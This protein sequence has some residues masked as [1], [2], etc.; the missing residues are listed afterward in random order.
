MNYGGDHTKRPTFLSPTF[1]FS[2]FLPSF[3]VAI[4]F[5]LRLPSNRPSII[6]F[7]SFFF[8]LGPLHHSCEIYRR[9]PIISTL[10]FPQL[11]PSHTLSCLRFTV[12]ILILFYLSLSLALSVS[13]CVCL[14]VSLIPFTDLPSF[15]EVRLLI[16]HLFL[17]V[18]PL[19]SPHS[20]P[21]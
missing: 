6:F 13:L 20:Q 5:I 4:F 17:Y 10:L 7:Y 9:P 2:S 3:L 16:L 1:S 18:H 11:V 8:Q 19:I 21:P 12:F 14:S 15:R